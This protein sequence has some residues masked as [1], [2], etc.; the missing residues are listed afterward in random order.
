[1]IKRI[2]L[3]LLGVCLT[4]CVEDVDFSQVNDLEITPGVAFPLV[5]TELVQDQLVFSGFEVGTLT[6]IS[7]ITILDNATAQNDLERVLLQFEITN[8]FDRE[9][10]IDFNF[11]DENNNSTN[12]SFSLNIPPNA[13]QFEEEYEIIIANNPLFLNTRRVEVSFT[14]LPS[15]DG[16]VIDEN[17]PANLIFKSAGIFYLRVN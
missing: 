2:V 4:S 3:F 8:Q 1:M 6:Q 9:F 16:S 17:V 10:R 11:L 14:L 12:T 7:E 15:S 5:N 13:Q